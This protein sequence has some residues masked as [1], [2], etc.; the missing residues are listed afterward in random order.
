MTGFIWMT[1]FVDWSEVPIILGTK[2][3]ADVLGVHVNTVKQLI[4]KGDLPAFKV[5]RVLKVNKSDLKRYAKVCDSNDEAQA[6]P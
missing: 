2:E 6:N 3:V 5:G 4:T 1:K